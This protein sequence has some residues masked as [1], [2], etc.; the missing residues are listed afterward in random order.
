M[1]TMNTEMQ[2]MAHDINNG[3][4]IDLHNAREVAEISRYAHTN[5]IYTP[6]F[7][8]R[9]AATLKHSIEAGVYRRTSLPT[10]PPA[11]LMTALRSRV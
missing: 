1:S 3:H 6:N 10:P 8:N 4:I 7:E 9:L 11:S 5:N 2:N